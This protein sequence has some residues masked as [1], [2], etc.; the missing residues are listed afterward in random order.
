MNAAGPSAGRRR[1]GFT[2]VEVLVASMLLGLS[3]ISLMTGLAACFRVF[4]A[5][6][7]LQGVQWVFG[8]AQLA[9]PVTDVEKLEDLV[10]EPD[11]SLADG[12][13]FSRTIDEKTIDGDEDDDDG[14]YV[15]RSRVS[16]GGGG[17]GE[18]E[19]LVQYVWKKGAGEYKP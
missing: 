8:L 2:L 19:E 7:E 4:R 9:Y 14:L 3:L 11:D 12:F 18:H 5:T 16:W 6:G 10:V 17:E 15:M 1:G 13:V